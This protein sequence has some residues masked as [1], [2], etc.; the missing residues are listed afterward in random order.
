LDPLTSFQVEQPKDDNN[1]NN[2]DIERKTRKEKRKEIR[3]IDKET[4][5]RNYMQ[6]ENLCAQRKKKNLCTKKPCF[7]YLQQ[8]SSQ[9]HHAYPPPTKETFQNCSTTM[10]MQRNVGDHR[11]LID[12]KNA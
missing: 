3:H 2:V 10:Q 5:E 6:R 9:S 12:T 1:F 11:R 7:P 8:T 4:K